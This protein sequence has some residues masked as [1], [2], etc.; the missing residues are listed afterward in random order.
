M[1]PGPLQLWGHVAGFSHDSHVTSGQ[2]QGALPATTVTGDAS[3]PGCVP[4]QGMW[5]GAWGA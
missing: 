3:D 5:R 4:E 2:A 1:F